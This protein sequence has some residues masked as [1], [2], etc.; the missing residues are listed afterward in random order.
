MSISTNVTVA[1][2][3]DQWPAQKLS[4]NSPLSQQ[5]LQ[6]DDI[7]A[8]QSVFIQQGA[9]SVNNT[10]HT[11]NE[12]IYLAPHARVEL[13][14]NTATT[15]VRFAF[16]TATLDANAVT[17]RMASHPGQNTETSTLKLCK[18]FTLTQPSVIFRL[19]RVNFPPGSVAYRHTHPGA[20]LRYLSFGSLQLHT[21]E[22]VHSISPG[23]A[24]FEAANSPV[25]AV[26][27]VH[28]PSQF[29]RMLLL[30]AE[31]EG[32]ASFTLANT[33]DADKPRLQTNHRYFDKN[34]SVN[35]N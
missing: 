27:D 26:A 2:F 6:P 7:H 19:D 3:V 24:W 18:T 23:D 9:L 4:S 13:P 21:D 12:G 15:A 5:I 28:K 1:V 14:A 32:K 8:H 30:P 35:K 17:S 29:I 22:S 16:I 34:I 20:G 10:L 31:Y 11:A 25:K 33:A